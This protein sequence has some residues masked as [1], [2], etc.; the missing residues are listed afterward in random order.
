MNIEEISLKMARDPKNSV[1][2]RSK[3]L[4]NLGLIYKN[5]GLYDKS[6]RFYKLAI[7]QDSMNL[8]AYKGLVFLYKNVFKKRFPDLKEIC[9]RTK[10]TELMLALSQ[11]IFQNE[12]N[13]DEALIWSYTSLL[14]EKGCVCHIVRDCC[15]EHIQKSFL[16]IIEQEN[17]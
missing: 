2:I 9:L 10:S 6:F 15:C 8:E 11:D 5:K 4:S 13:I 16:R 3:G 14:I 1:S 17:L 7:E 12:E